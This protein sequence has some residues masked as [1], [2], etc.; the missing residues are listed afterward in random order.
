MLKKRIFLL[1]I[2]TIFFSNFAKS[3]EIFIVGKVDN[4]IITNIDIELEK[5]YLLL[6]NNKLNKISK[7][8]FFK[9]AKNSLIREIIKKKEIKKSFK[10]PNKEFKDKITK[11]FYNKFGF[12]N[13]NDFIN[14]LKTKNINFENLKEKLIV[15]AFWNQL[16]FIKYNNKI[17]IDESSIK[18][19]VIKYFNSRDKKYEFNLSEIISI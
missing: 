9:L 5:N 10:K 17:R 18:N 3:Q 15:E 13:K 1:F 12:E 16:I 19:D 2:I 4:E 11:S 14:F 6:L 8:E 7:N